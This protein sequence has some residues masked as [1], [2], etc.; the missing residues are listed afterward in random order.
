MRVPEGAARLDAGQDLRQ[1]IVHR[2]QRAVHARGVDDLVAQAG[3]QV[4]EAQIDGDEHRAGVR[5]EEGLG[6]LELIPF[7]VGALAR[8]PG[9]RSAVVAPGQPRC[10]T[11][12]PGQRCCSSAHQI[13]GIARGRRLPVRMGRRRLVAD[14]GRATQGQEVRGRGRR[15]GGRCRPDADH[16]G[17]GH[18]CRRRHAGRDERRHTPPPLEQA[19]PPTDPPAEPGQGHGRPAPGTVVRTFSSA[20]LRAARATDALLSAAVTR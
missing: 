8:R 1:L 3:E 5:L 20:P 2:G 10:T 13:L 7:G 12:S 11:V 16:A 18:E 6:R 14:R 17:R 9:A 4:V 19:V 15:P